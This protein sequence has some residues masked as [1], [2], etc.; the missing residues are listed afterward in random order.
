VAGSGSVPY[1]VRIHLTPDQAV[2]PPVALGLPYVGAAALTSTE[3]WARF[4]RA[5][6][7]ERKG[8]LVLIRISPHSVDFDGILA[9][10]YYADLVALSHPY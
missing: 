9:D 6:G 2:C 5:G 7:P 4:I 10:G 3:E 8:P 1:V